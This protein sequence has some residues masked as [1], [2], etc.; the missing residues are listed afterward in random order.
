MQTERFTK[1]LDSL[2]ELQLTAMLKGIYSFQI[3]VNFYRANPEFGD[4]SDEYRIEATVFL[5]ED[6]DDDSNYLRVEFS[7]Q[8]DDAII[9]QR[10]VRIR[11]FIEEA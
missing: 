9:W 7:E 5:T 8:F 10:F 2:Q 1:L 4:E 11:K 6:L 3:D